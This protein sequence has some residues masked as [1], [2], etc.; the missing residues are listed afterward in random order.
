MNR[1]ILL[2]APRSGTTWLGEILNASP[3]VAYRY[4][5]L[6]AWSFASKVHDQ[7]S[8]SEIEQFFEDLLDA[9]DPYV[10]KLR[11]SALGAELP[12]FR[13]G[14]VTHLVFKETHYPTICSRLVKMT[15][16]TKLVGLI[17]DPVDCLTSWWNVENEFA[18]E[19]SIAEEWLEAPSKN[20]GRAGH[21]AGFTG[22]LK[23]IRTLLALRDT[24]SRKTHLISY[25]T[26][27]RDPQYVTADLFAHLELP[28]DPQVIDFMSSSTSREDPN[29]Y[30]VFR[31][32]PVPR[33]RGE[34]PGEIAEK[35]RQRTRE[36]GLSE[37][38]RS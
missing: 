5:P 33:P 10:T 20:R 26:L 1:T 2:G 37:F 30:G 24:E 34:L 11:S 7:S 36:E 3:Q 22:W 18:D 13:K 4:Q 27:L 31:T 12:S 35:I 15:D 25:E 23:V 8:R 6:H 32:G 21:V 16:D 17:R 9:K 19:W 28:V 38:L 14:T 29:P